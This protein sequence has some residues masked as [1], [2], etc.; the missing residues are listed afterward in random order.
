M[1]ELAIGVTI[2]V[3][4]FVS[5]LGGMIAVTRGDA[6]DVDPGDVQRGGRPP[7]RPTPT[8]VS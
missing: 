8:G 3:G 7:R 6:A 5:L 2:M 1:L 4:L